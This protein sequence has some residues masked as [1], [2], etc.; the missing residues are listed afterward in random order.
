M[1]ASMFEPTQLKT[2]LTGAP[3]FPL[4]QALTPDHFDF[5]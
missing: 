4:N 3:T 5:T 1:N 2:L